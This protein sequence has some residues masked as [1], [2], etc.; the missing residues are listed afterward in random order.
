MENFTSP[1]LPFFNILIVLSLRHIAHSQCSGSIARVLPAS[2][3]SF[4]Y[5]T[6]LI[7]HPHLVHRSDLFSLSTILFGVHHNSERLT[8]TFLFFI[9]TCLADEV[10]AQ[11]AVSWQVRVNSGTVEKGPFDI[12]FQPLL[13]VCF[14]RNLFRCLPVSSSSLT[15]TYI[16]P[17]A[18]PIS[19][20]RT[21]ACP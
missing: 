12:C 11:P 16:L 18:R 5:W 6:E 3:F 21:Y 1:S 14:L 13:C 10:M 19:T 4:G 20:V 2:R 8:D 17:S 15:S 9:G 7:L